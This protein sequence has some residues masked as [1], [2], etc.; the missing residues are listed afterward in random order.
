MG[1][2]MRTRAF[3]HAQN[4]QIQIILRKRKVASGP[5]HHSYILK[6]LMILLEGSEGPDQTA[7]MPENTFRMTRSI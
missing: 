7:H 3:E 1:L 2:V 5:L 4:V 6:Y